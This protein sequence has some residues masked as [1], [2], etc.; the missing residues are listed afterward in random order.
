MTTKSNKVAT[1][2]GNKKISLF[3]VSEL[4]TWLYR[5]GLSCY[6]STEIARGF[7]K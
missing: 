3:A 5:F 7:L 2:Q 6:Y 1:I 4:Q